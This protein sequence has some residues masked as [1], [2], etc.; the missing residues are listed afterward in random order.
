M[1]SVEL[2]K[3][4]DILNG[5]NV[6]QLLTYDKLFTDTTFNYPEQFH[7]DSS[8]SKPAYQY[9]DVMGIKKKYKSI[10]IE[11]LICYEKK[12]CKTGRWCRICNVMVCAGCYK[13]CRAQSTH[14]PISVIN[15]S[16]K[17][18]TQECPRAWQP[19]CPKCRGEGSFGTKGVQATRIAKIRAYGDGADTVYKQ[20]GP[21]VTEDNE[22]R[23]VT[24][25]YVNEYNKIAVYLNGDMEAERQGIKQSIEFI[26]TNEEYNNFCDDING[27]GDAIKS[28]KTE[29]EGIESRIWT[30]R[31]EKT[32]IERK[33]GEFVKDN[34][35]YA[36]PTELPSSIGKGDMDSLSDKTS[37][38]YNQLLRTK[39]PIW[40]FNH[41][42]NTSF[43]INNDIDIASRSY[44]STHQYSVD[45]GCGYNLNDIMR[46]GYFKSLDVKLNAV[47]TTYDY[48]LTG[49]IN[50]V[51]PESP[52]TMEDDELALMIQKLQAEQK[53]RKG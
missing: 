33:R 10:N 41:N 26:R 9:V 15:C 48:L 46:G 51:I 35:H 7:N 36:P 29:I 53:R 49:A 23:R 30:L 18:Y 38:G 25:E 12:S 20:F 8:L 40:F 37:S 21:D 31:C 27:K 45:D 32:A 42:L 3:Q 24:R 5:E 43:D 34:A 16:D 28:L 11:C 19:R 22:L 17:P 47:K 6:T 13:S 52:D 1:T 4:L 2:R 44:F 50:P 39:Y 14:R